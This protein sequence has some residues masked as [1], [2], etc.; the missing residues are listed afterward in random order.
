MAEKELNNII[1]GKISRIQD[2]LGD[3]GWIGYRGR[4]LGGG[5]DKT[6]QG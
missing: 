6:K 5:R 1:P 2:R 4:G 3:P